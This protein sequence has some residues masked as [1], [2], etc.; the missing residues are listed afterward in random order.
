[1]S[2]LRVE[3]WRDVE[4]RAMVL[5]FDHGEVWLGDYEAAQTGGYRA[6]EDEIAKARRFF[7]EQRLACGCCDCLREID[8]KPR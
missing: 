1:M 4:Q 5:R 6:A 3:Q 2:I 8:M 7:H